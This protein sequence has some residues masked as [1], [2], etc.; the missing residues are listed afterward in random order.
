MVNRQTRGQLWG[1][2][3]R[4]LR[5]LDIRSESG[6]TTMDTNDLEDGGAQGVLGC[7]EGV[8]LGK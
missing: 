6:D 2:W 3:L 5:P 1:W 7:T 8:S 4:W